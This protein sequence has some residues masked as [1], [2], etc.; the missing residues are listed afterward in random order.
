MTDVKDMT[1]SDLRAMATQVADEQ[2]R[3]ARAAIAAQ[4]A[5]PKPDAAKVEIRGQQ[6]ETIGGTP[7]GEHLEPKPNGQQ[8]D[9]V[10]LSDAER[11]KGFVRPVRAA[12]RHTGAR[13]AHPVR[14]LTPDEQER[15]K[16]QDYVSFETY[17][18]EMAPRTGRFWTAA[19]LKSGCGAVTTMGSALA[20]TWARDIGFYSGTF[21]CSCATHLPVDEFVWDGTSERLGT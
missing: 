13:P 2:H 4:L 9:Y 15:Y 1:D 5:K 3:R 7:Y 6:A 20:E 17:P 21:C 16:D 10:V 18:A 11:A 19:R 12:Y 8:K 14:D